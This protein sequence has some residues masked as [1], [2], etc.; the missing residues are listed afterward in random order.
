MV[1]FIC[2]GHKGLIM[3]IARVGTP[4]QKMSVKKP[5]LSL[6]R[7][8]KPKLLDQLREALRARHYSRRTE[9]TYCSWVKRFI[10][11]HHVR[12]P[13]EMAEPE[14]NDFLTHRKRSLAR[15]EK[16]LWPSVPPA[17]SFGI[18][19]RRIFWKGVT[20]FGQ[21]KNSSAIRT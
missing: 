14:I 6:V 1:F 9:R 10:F 19:L 3:N 20:T 2:E 16:P 8:A 11:F 12:H 5:R 21:S 7:D 15:S 4:S 17:T 13:K 18:P